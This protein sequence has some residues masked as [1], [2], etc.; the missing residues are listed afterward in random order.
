MQLCLELLR[1]F[2]MNSSKSQSFS[3]VNVYLGVV[4]QQAFPGTAIDPLQCE[5]ENGRVGFDKIDIARQNN[6]VK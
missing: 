4:N 3:C 1:R 5:V 2:E 6:S